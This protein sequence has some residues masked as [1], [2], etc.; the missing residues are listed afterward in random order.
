MVFVVFALL[1]VAIFAGI[2]P[3]GQSKNTTT[4]TGKVVIWGTIPSKY[5]HD[6]LSTFSTINQDVQVTYEE[7]DPATFDTEFIN[8]LAAAKGPDAIIYSAEDFWR[9]RNKLVHIPFESFPAR[10]FQDSYIQGASVFLDTDGVVGFPFIVDPMIMYWNRDLFTRESI[11][12]P[13]ETW[14]ELTALVPQLTKRESDL[15]VNQSTVAFGTYDNITHAKDIISLLFLGTGNTITKNIPGSQLVSVLTEH[16][17]GSVV[18]PAFAAMDFYTAFSNPVKDVYSW[19]RALAPSRESF[20]KGTLAVYFGFASELPG[21][22]KENP[23]LNFDVAFMP[24]STS[25]VKS[26]M[27]HFYAIGVTN[28]STNKSSAILVASLFSGKDFLGDFHTKN[29]TSFTVPPVRIDLLEKKSTDP[30][31]T[32]FYDAA[33]VAKTWIDPSPV[34]TENIFR[35]MI[36]DISSGTLDVSQAVG[37]ANDRL[38]Q[39]AA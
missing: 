34:E 2:I 21:I 3:V 39:L 14:E 1:A 35:D 25:A 38:A 31:L 13:P 27:G 24:Q 9:Y 36:T 26:T 18:V 15:T 12:T 16:A 8:A 22:R 20:V 4:A 11:V 37:K 28:A 17:P 23:N 33:L 29:L 5:L 32:I 30:Y 10:K 6:S 19:N 7:K